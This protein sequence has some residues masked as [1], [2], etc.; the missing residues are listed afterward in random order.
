V[1]SSCVC[2]V[3]AAPGRP[4]KALLDDGILVV[5]K[6]E[7]ASDLG[8]GQRDQTADLAGPARGGFRWQR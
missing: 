4:T 8:E 2:L 5:K 3:L 6:V 7:Q 1:V